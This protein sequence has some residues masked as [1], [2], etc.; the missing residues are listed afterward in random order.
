MINMDWVKLVFIACGGQF[1]LDWVLPTNW[2][3]KNKVIKWL[4][5]N[6]QGF[7]SIGHRLDMCATFGWIHL[8]FLFISLP[9]P[10]GS[11]LFWFN[12]FGNLYPSIVQLYIGYRLV[13]VKVVRYHTKIRV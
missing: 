13:R 9:A 4:W 6:D 11:V 10:V 7:R 12:I 8:P 3:S 1:Y 2:S 5:R